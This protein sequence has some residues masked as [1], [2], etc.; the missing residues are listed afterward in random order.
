M[1]AWLTNLI[2]GILTG[3]VKRQFHQILQNQAVL[4]NDIKIII[5]RLEDLEADFTTSK[6]RIF[7]QF[8]RFG[9]WEYQDDQ[10]SKSNGISIPEE[11]KLLGNAYGLDLDKAVG[12]DHAELSKIKKML[13]LSG[14]SKK[15]PEW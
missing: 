12:G 10:V 3:V 6:A 9:T 8:R 7:K 15:S 14:E 1:F 13:N 11:L 4:D 5:N 2:Q